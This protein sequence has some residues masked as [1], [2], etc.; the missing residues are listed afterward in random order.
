MIL[1]YSG[2]AER[3]DPASGLGRRVGA[4]LA[5]SVTFLPLNT[6]RA[7]LVRDHRAL[8][9]GPG[10]LSFEEYLDYRLHDRSAFPAERD[11][12]RFIS[13]ETQADL[14]A[15]VC[16][17]DAA[18]GDAWAME[19]R[20]HATDIPTRAS[21]AVVNGD[22]GD[23]GN[24][25]V[26]DDAALLDDFLRTHDV[27]LVARPAE[28]RQEVPSLRIAA[29]G[30]GRYNV[31]G[32]GVVCVQTLYSRLCEDNGPWLLH[33]ASVPHPDLAAFAG[34]RG[35]EARL[36]VAVFAAGETAHVPSCTLCFPESLRSPDTILATIDPATGIVQPL[37]TGRGMDRVTFDT[38]PGGARCMA[39]AALPCWSDIMALVRR[40]PAALAPMRW[41]S[42]DIALTARGPIVLTVAP[43]APAALHQHAGGRGFLSDAVLDLLDACG[44]RVTLPRD[45][46]VSLPRAR[47]QP[48]RPA[49]RRG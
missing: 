1:A 41:Y 38:V 13:L 25:P 10:R 4:F 46:R 34:P 15:R 32:L 11:R 48:L 31:S 17:P 47:P 14:C 12:H 24:L 23:F 18:S 20:L 21:I 40:T 26:L 35:G 19:R 45:R 36:S 3:A 2:K 49:G 30:H 43:G 29:L 22:G 33:R 27:P 28:T 16:G 44:A 39:G 5:R 42:L 6:D 7:A 9:R 8:S 37:V